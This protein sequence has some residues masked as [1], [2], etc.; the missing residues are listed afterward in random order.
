M[1][2][3]QHALEHPDQPAI[4]MASSGETVTFAEYE[5]RC[6]ATAQLLRAAGLQRGDHIAVFMENQPRLLE[7]EGAAE[8]A[9]L[10]YTLIN[11]YLAPDE[12]A[13]IITNSQSRLLF[14]S[15]AR[16]PVAV[17]AAAKC[18][19]LEGL[20]MAG[21][22]S[23]PPG[24]Q[25]YEAAVADFPA[26]PIPDES[27]GAAMLYSSGTT[28]QPK[29][30]LRQLPD[31]A[32]SDPL[33]VMQFVTA[34]F[35][36]RPGMTY[37]NPAPLYHS[38]PQASVGASIRL[39]A[40]SVVMEHFDA[41]Q[42]LALVER[43]RVTNCQMVPSMFSRL[44]RLPVEVRK[45]YDTS[46]LECI[47]HAAAPCP[48]HVK[49]GM[50]D[51]L[52]PVITEYYGATEANGFTFCDSAQWLAHPGT[53]GSPILGELL[54]LDEDGNQCPTGTDGT[55]WFR[56]ATAFQYFQEPEKTAASRT[57]DGMTSTVGDVGHVDD[58]GYLY[59]TDRKSYMIISGGVNIYPQETE[60]LL[61]GHPAVLDVAVI[62]VPNEDLGEEVKAVV[63]LADAVAASPELAQE[64]ISYC[65]DRMAHFK[66]PRTVD[67]VV[68]LPRT[69]TG[70]LVKRLLRD[71]Y[72]A[73]HKT[74]IV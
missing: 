66:C 37:L 43:Y 53:V 67:F 22:D 65:R 5:A 69:E 70:K 7:I 58:E 4:I 51:W 16:Q 41:Q 64:L 3:R 2:A 62:G 48:E 60:N 32:P 46:S 33:P 30:I 59:L 68:E 17:A 52:G 31:A 23:P 10:Y 15:A 14:S 72:W 20:F 39:G 12:V 61:S 38:A 13:Y 57:A 36:F 26:D 9:G 44:L 56:G 18:P 1:F 19:Q 25:A 71:K 6:N 73:G 54:I 47:V 27:L 45:G 24:W 55:V 8:R 74:S 42:W 35:G 29:G 40:T 11:I 28:G 63:Q 21:T 49:R 34:M 50:I